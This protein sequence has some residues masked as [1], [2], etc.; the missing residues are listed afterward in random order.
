MNS[1]QENISSINKQTHLLVLLE[2]ELAKSGYLSQD[3]LS[4]LA[5]ST[6]ISLSEIYGVVS[7]YSFLTDKP[8]GRNI[9]RICNNLP[10]NLKHS[11]M[12]INNI[13]RELG[14]KPGQTTV[15]GK[16]TLTLTNCIG[17][18]DKAPA[19]LINNDVHGDL[20]PEKITKI[21]NS[22]K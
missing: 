22:Y 8:Q 11:E 5:Q 3:Y 18:C 20:T 21:L 13:T 14:I 12:I 6:N 9:I 17:A 16:F 7:F 2:K 10:C 4:N 1:S 15:D 19:M